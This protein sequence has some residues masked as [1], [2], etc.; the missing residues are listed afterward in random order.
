MDRKVAPALNLEN[1]TCVI[2]CCAY[3]SI[4]ADE[5]DSWD[6]DNMR[7]GDANED[8][9]QDSHSPEK[10]LHGPEKSSK[11]FL[12]LPPLHQSQKDKFKNK[13]A[14]CQGLVGDTEVVHSSSTNQ[15]QIQKEKGVYNTNIKQIW[16]IIQN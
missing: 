8:N 7:D 12:T 15:N 10:D 16:S 1:L 3:P 5:G 13:A 9:Q 11:F 6:E 2:H 4:T 14:G